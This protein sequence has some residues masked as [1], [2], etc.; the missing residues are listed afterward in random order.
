MNKHIRNI[1]LYEIGIGTEGKKLHDF[2]KYQFSDLEE[3]KDDNIS[4]SLF[5]GKSKDNIIM[6]WS[7]Y[8]EQDQKNDTLFVI[9]KGLWSVFEY[10]FHMKHIE[11]QQLILW[12]F[13]RKLNL[14]ATNTHL[15]VQ[16]FLYLS[17]VGRELNLK[18]N[19]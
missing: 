18:V 17:T 5:Y 3:Y 7:E 15:L 6:E 19:K 2:L 10:R 16:S 1:K 9:Y 12:W 13:D 4:N 11:I 8:K 14:K